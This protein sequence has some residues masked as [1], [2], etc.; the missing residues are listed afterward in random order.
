VR[1]VLAAAIDRRAI[2]LFEEDAPIGLV[3]PER[4]DESLLEEYRRLA[5]AELELEARN[6]WSA[7]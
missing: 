4:L 3:P 1:E 2:E 6:R 5:A 7:S